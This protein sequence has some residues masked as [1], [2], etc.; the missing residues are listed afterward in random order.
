M[1]ESAFRR[2]CREAMEETAA[3][4]EALRSRLR[5]A[6]SATEVFSA[7]EGEAFAPLAAEVRGELEKVEQ[8]QFAGLDTFNVVLFGRTGAGK[9]S[10]IEAI[11]RGTGR[12][13]SP[14]GRPDHTRK[15]CGRVWGPLKVYDSPGFAGMEQAAMHAE[16]EKARRAAAAADVVVL[17]FDDSGQRFEEFATVARWIGD[18]G[19]VAVAVLNVKNPRWRW[20]GFGALDA[21]VAGHARR[22]REALAGVGLSRTPV[23][24]VH[25]QN[26]MFARTGPVYKGPAPAA[27]EVL[28]KK[29]GA[30]GLEELSNL[31][32][33]EDLLTELVRAGGA[34]LRLGSVTHFAEAALDR[35]RDRFRTAAQEAADAA[36]PAERTVAEVLK[37][38]GLPPPTPPRPAADPTTGSDAGPTAGP[39]YGTFRADLRRLEALRGATFAVP[40]VPRAAAYGRDLAVS[41]F[42]PLERDTLARA[43]EYIDERI[44]ERKQAPAGAFEEA[45]YA[46]DLMEDA[47]RRVFEDY[48]R[49]LRRSHEVVVHR[50]YEEFRAV[51][52]DPV[53][54]AGGRGKWLQR[55]SVGGSVAG[56]AGS[57]AFFVLAGPVGWGVAGAVAL[58]GTVL[59]VAGA[60]G[61]KRAAAAR[62]QGRTESLAEAESAISALFARLAR[63][64]E[65]ELAG[66]RRAAVAQDA[67]DGVRTALHHRGMRSSCLGVLAVLPA[68]EPDGAG[69]YARPQQLVDRALDACERRQGVGAGAERDALWLGAGARPQRGLIAHLRRQ[70]R[71]DRADVRLS[72]REFA[73]DLPEPLPKGTARAWIK[74]VDAA[75]GEVSTLRQLRALAA[76]PGPAVVFCG[77]YDSGKSSLVRRLLGGSA[78]IATGPE[79]ETDRV[80][81]HPH[82][83][84]LTLVDTPGFQATAA[85]ADDTTMRE[86]ATAALVVMVFTPGLATCDPTDLRRVLYGDP[87]AHLP[88]QLDRCL[89][90]V[91][92]ADGFGTDPELD[93]EGFAAL[94][95]RKLAQVRK[96]VPGLRHGVALAAAPFGTE[97]AR[98][99]DGV[100]EFAA[101]LTALRRR[102]ARDAADIAVL[103]GGRILLGERLAELVRERDH[104]HYQALM[105]RSAHEEDQRLRAEAEVLYGERR[106][107]LRH[108]VGRLIDEAV[109]QTLTTASKDRRDSLA[110][111]LE[112]LGEDPQF[113]RITAEWGRLTDERTAEFE[114]VC[115][116]RTDL[117]A[118]QPGGREDFPTLGPLPDARTLGAEDASVAGQAV[119]WAGKAGAVASKVERFVSGG[120]KGAKLL[121]NAAPTLSVLGG[122]LSSYLLV[123]ELMDASQDEEARRKAVR[124]LHALGDAW[125][126]AALDQDPALRRLHALYK[127]LAAQEGAGKTEAHARE[128]E[129]RTLAARA[130]ACGALIDRATALLGAP[131]GPDSPADPAPGGPPQGTAYGTAYD[132]PDSPS[133]GTSGGTN[134]RETT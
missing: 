26:A 62:E 28:L 18:H 73:A 82:H 113:R 102:L 105:A 11:T 120:G 94:R 34:E 92:R 35:A 36:E 14:D 121:K 100:R 27:R 76:R 12:L 123:T 90:V 7:A 114:A 52:A 31:P 93:P 77:D 63:L 88:G 87:A 59:E 110:R 128:T 117:A 45:V 78:D 107:D 134:S 56:I 15:V 129:E 68:P 2:A 108:R 84:G 57:G 3:R 83:S 46:H 79:P 104:A 39:G 85:R 125:A 118:G 98:P 5:L 70:G 51:Q 101:E 42:S 71:P 132:T 9:S 60:Q 131:A 47:T 19:K 75:L 8:E 64:V 41:R 106:E 103:S 96:A 21:A 25:A 124:R 97:Q 65:Q 17:C 69:A 30:P 13:A 126:T 89:F 33:L 86:I 38:L 23:V 111:R 72:I 61:R 6:I 24:A 95:E 116:H 32:A 91:N 112:R 81:R 66:M 43:R 40:A 55:T 16:L 1:E 74:E 58:G 99:W 130:V 10:L 20:D 29:F 54:V 4:T 115:A 127:T 109:S 48:A 50:L 53:D 122:V 67:T 49:F 80:G 119:G 37:V 133:G 22:V 44:A